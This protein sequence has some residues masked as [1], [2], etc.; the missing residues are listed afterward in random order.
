MQYYVNGF[1]GG[2]PDIREAAPGRALIR[3]R[4]AKPCANVTLPRPTVR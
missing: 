1:K 2:D 4:R 3:P